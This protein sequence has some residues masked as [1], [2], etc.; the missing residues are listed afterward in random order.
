M[1]LQTMATSSYRQAIRAR[2][3]LEP[4][5]RYLEA[6]LNDNRM[7]NQ[8]CQN[9]STIIRTGVLL[10]RVAGRWIQRAQSSSCHTWEPAAGSDF[11]AIILD[12]LD[13]ES[14]EYLGHN[15]ELDPQFFSNHLSGCE[16]HY[17]G[18]WVKSRMTA[19]AY[20]QSA[21]RNSRYTSFDYRRAYPIYS[22]TNFG[23]FDNER[24]QKCGLLRSYHVATAAE[25]ILQHERF[26][27]AWFPGSKSRSVG[28]DNTQAFQ[29]VL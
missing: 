12:Y 27:I 14:I 1:N 26:S 3:H 10:D 13:S 17:T 20:L 28:R 15:L 19:A 16:Q 24:I 9:R 25:V 22:E 29:S 7:G 6:F 5:L 23:A 11:Q 18:D 2:A 21:R 8:A 4:D